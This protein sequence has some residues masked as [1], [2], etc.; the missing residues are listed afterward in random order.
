MKTNTWMLPLLLGCSATAWAAPPDRQ[1]RREEKQ[2]RRDDRMDRGEDRADRR[3]RARREMELRRTLRIADELE[4]DESR[5][6]AIRD[7]LRQGDEKRRQIGEAV[8]AEVQELRRLADGS[9]TLADVDGRI[10][11]IQELRAQLLRAE[12]DELNAA[13]KGLTPQQK[14]RLAIVLGAHEREMKALMLRQVVRDRRGGRDRGGDN[15][16]DP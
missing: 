5:A 16:G 3:D 7:V 9:P 13:A 15:F 14:A 12:E 2:D 8:R 10:R 6:L 11:K 4:L 1:T